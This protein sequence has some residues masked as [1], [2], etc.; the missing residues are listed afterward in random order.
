MGWGAALYVEREFNIAESMCG[1][2]LKNANYKYWLH[3]INTRQ[4][5]SLN[6]LVSQLTHLIVIYM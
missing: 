5:L 1:S 3:I 2:I 6:D 4:C